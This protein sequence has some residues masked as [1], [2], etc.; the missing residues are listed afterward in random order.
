MSFVSSITVIITVIII[1]Y[2]LIRI[3]SILFRITGIPREKAGFQTV[4]LL[5]TAGFTTGESEIIVSQKTRRHIATA[6]MLTGYFFSVVIVSL[7]INLFL[8]IDFS[9]FDTELAIMFVGFGGLALFFGFL[10]IPFVQ[11]ALNK[12]IEDITFRAFEKASK[13]NFISVLDTYGKEAVVNIFLYKVPEFLEG[14]CLADSDIR[15][16]Y[17]VNILM[18]TRNGQNHYV[19]PDT[20][21]SSKDILI[22]FGPLASIKEAFLLKEHEIK[23]EKKEEDVN[24]ITIMSNF[25]YQALVDIN[26]KKVP[27]ILEDKSLLESRIKDYFSI[28]IMMVSRKNKPLNLTKDTVIKKGDRVIAFGP[29]ENIHSV[30]GVRK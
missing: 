9:K 24:E 13:E 27:A 4:S 1:Y 5:T 7:F 11:N 23:V 8:S 16:K 29:Y 3:F 12:G 6:A 20:I 22:A 19:Q 18:Y 17:S 26:L 15:K 25:G 2:A 10:R 14:K 21:F 28:N 30:F